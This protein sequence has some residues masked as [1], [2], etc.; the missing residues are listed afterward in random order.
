MWRWSDL[1][2]STK[3][4]ILCFMIFFF[5][6]VYLI[7]S[8]GA[9]GTLACNGWNKCTFTKEPCKISPLLVF[10]KSI[11]DFMFSLFT[12]SQQANMSISSTVIDIYFFSWL[13]V[14]SL[15]FRTPFYKKEKLRNDKFMLFIHIS[16]MFK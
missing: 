14:G 1:K 7:L 9:G 13:E 2:Q 6:S 15:N 3:S 16:L 5:C 8:T 12:V 11:I 10:K 4:F